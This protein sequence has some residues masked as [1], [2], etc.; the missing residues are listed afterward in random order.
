MM[1]IFR[2]IKL[3]LFSSGFILASHNAYAMTDEEKEKLPKGL[4]VVKL[5]S[6]GSNELASSS[7]P[8]LQ[9]VVDELSA[10]LAL[11]SS[12]GESAMPSSSVPNTD[13]LND[14]EEEITTSS[15]SPPTLKTNSIHKD[16]LNDIAG[17]LAPV[18]SALKTFLESPLTS[19]QTKRQSVSSPTSPREKRKSIKSR[20]RKNTL[21]ISSPSPNNMT[22][23]SVENY[24]EE[25]PNCLR[26]FSNKFKTVDY[27]ILPRERQEE[28]YQ[29]L[30][31]F[32]DVEKIYKDHIN[33]EYFSTIENLYNDLHN[34]TVVDTTRRFHLIRMATA[35]IIK[36]AAAARKAAEEAA[37][38]VVVEETSSEGD[39]MEGYTLSRGS[40][41]SSIPTPPPL[42]PRGNRSFP[43]SPPPA[44]PGRS[45]N[46]SSS[47]VPL[48]LSLQQEG[49]S[50]PRPLPVPPSGKTPSSSF[51]VSP[52][53][54]SAPT[55][56]P[57]SRSISTPVRKMVPPTSPS[58]TSPLPNRRWA[59][60]HEGP[61][62]LSSQNVPSD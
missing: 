59:Q 25:L 32:R 47:S 50:S 35:P 45:K 5:L 30:C 4:P 44:P 14:S 62:D 23:T 29:L 1:S 28:F 18:G 8:L 12:E 13:T 20:R 26:E 61:V 3:A 60:Y 49:T 2:K 54:S 15:S 57:R 7:S 52:P 39:G 17:R 34:I 27:M 16:K 38:Q 36:E 48:L 56:P 11:K 37:H 10:H 40:S 53:S 9:C 24:Q 43:S 33:H 46:E 21:E 58:P 51:S 22:S 55:R 31:S 42:S 41:L 19:P 6:G